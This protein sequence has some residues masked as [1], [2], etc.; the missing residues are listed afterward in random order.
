MKIERYLHG[1]YQTFLPELMLSGSLEVHLKFLSRFYFLILEQLLFILTPFI[2]LI[3]SCPQSEDTVL[4]SSNLSWRDQNW[5]NWNN[6][7]K[8]CPDLS[9]KPR[10]REEETVTKCKNGQ[11][12]FT[13]FN[14]FHL[15]SIPTTV[16]GSFIIPLY[17][18]RISSWWG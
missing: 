18:I 5:M 8:H 6:F 17:I 7:L 9:L 10:I 3:F 15:L 16:T 13:Q 2:A 14:L 1:N 4:H 12:N 11:L